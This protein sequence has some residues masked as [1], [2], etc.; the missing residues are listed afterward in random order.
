MVKLSA[1][2][3]HIA[4]SCQLTV[5]FSLTLIVWMASIQAAYFLKTVIQMKKT[6]LGFL[7]IAFVIVGL[8]SC[9]KD[10]V[11]PADPSA[12][13]INVSSPDV[14]H[15]FHNGE[16]V[17]VVANV[18]YITSLIGYDFYITNRTSG[19]TLYHHGMDENKDAFTITENWVDTCTVPTHLQVTIFA[20]I[21]TYGANA[22]KLFFLEAQ[23]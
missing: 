20:K 3:C 18:T 22:Y 16:T 7:F 10:S 8:A 2:V 11:V 5:L 9:Q 23:P 14:S 12:V 15:I 1:A 21:N 13:T 17:S 19:D 4:C 6:L